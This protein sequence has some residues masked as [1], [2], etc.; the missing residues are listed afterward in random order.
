MLMNH[1][2]MNLFDDRSNLMGLVDSSFLS[3]KFFLAL[4]DLLYYT[5]F[6]MSDNDWLFY[7][8]LYNCFLMSM[9]VNRYLLIDVSMY[10]F[11][12]DLLFLTKLDMSILVKLM[13]M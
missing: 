12:V 1:I 11:L 8:F 5:L 2:L 4:V 3:I 13:P 7:N 6:M 9:L 10:L